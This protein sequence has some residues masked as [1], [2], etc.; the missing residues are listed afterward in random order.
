MNRGRDAN[1]YRIEAERIRKLAQQ[2]SNAELRDSYLELSK[3][4]ESLAD[5]LERFR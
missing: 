4:Y 3:A 2:E 1:W 5:M